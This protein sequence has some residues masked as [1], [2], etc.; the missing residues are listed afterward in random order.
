MINATCVEVRELFRIEDER[1]CY[2]HQLGKF[3][4]RLF[5]LDVVKTKN[6]AGIIPVTEVERITKMEIKRMLGQFVQVEF[7]KE[8]KESKTASGIVLTKVETKKY[9]T[10]TVL[11]VGEEC[12]KNLQVGDRVIVNNYNENIRLDDSVIVK[13]LDII[14]V[15]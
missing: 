9:K 11:M 2:V 12:E 5:P 3:V 10:A 14:A 13:E 1:I 4:R 6:F 15:I 8:E 7:D